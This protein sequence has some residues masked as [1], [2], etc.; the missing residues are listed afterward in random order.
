MFF[1]DVA[2]TLPQTLTREF[3]GSAVLGNRSYDIF[4]ST[5]RDLGRNLKCHSDLGAI[6]AIRHQPHRRF[7]EQSAGLAAAPN[8]AD[9]LGQG[10]CERSRL[11]RL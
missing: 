10:V 4:R 5:G 7:R 1:P 2:A 8:R 11:R 6:F 3:Q 9:D